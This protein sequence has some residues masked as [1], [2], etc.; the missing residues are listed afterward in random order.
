MQVWFAELFLGTFY[1]LHNYLVW[2]SFVKYA[3][4][5]FVLCCIVFLEKTSV[6]FKLYAEYGWKEIKLK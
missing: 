4:V 6:A 2:I 5:I 3:S 1:F